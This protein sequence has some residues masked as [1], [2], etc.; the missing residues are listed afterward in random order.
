[1]KKTPKQL[2]T[3][4]LLFIFVSVATIW[5]IVKLIAGG[6][7]VDPGS[8]EMSEDAIAERLKPVGQVSVVSSPDDSMPPEAVSSAQP[9]GGSET[10]SVAKM[11][12]T[13]ETP[14]AAAPAH[15]GELVYNSSCKMCHGTGIAGAP[16]VGDKAAWQARIAQ[17]IDVLYASAINGKNTMPPKGGAMGTPDGDIK[18]AVDIMVSKSR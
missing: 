16:K 10:T 1:L 14:G 12:G 3:T 11:P 18:S 6:M 13:S 9:I 8:P 2:V 4:V 5:L 7:N 17:G 15:A